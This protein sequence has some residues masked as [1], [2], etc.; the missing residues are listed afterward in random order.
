[1]AT[2]IGFLQNCNKSDVAYCYDLHDR[3]VCFH[4][5]LRL[6]SRFSC[7]VCW[8]PVALCCAHLLRMGAQIPDYGLRGGGL[9]VRSIA[10]AGLELASRNPERPGQA[11]LEFRVC[12]ARLRQRSLFDRDV[13][14]S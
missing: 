11:K 3:G 10:M 9:A 2:F 6:G 7:C 5:N 12:G 8:I 14:G 1:M 4:W 13:Y